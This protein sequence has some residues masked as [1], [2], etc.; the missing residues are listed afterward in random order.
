LLSVTI[1][2]LTGSRPLTDNYTNKLSRPQ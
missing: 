1:L 2:V